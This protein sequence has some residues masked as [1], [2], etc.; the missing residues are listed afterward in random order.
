MHNDETH[1]YFKVSFVINTLEHVGE[2]WGTTSLS[3]LQI[4]V[5]MMKVSVLLNCTLSLYI[6]M[7]DGIPKEKDNKLD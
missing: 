4:K 5:S 1:M 7:E 3:S 2:P 6:V